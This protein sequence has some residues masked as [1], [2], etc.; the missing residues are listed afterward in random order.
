[1]PFK[2]AAEV[3]GDFLDYFSL[4]AEIVGVYLGKVAAKVCLLRSTR[5]SR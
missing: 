2:P 5:N 4:T 1:M 3:G